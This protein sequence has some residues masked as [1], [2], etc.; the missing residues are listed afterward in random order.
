MPIAEIE[1]KN[2][3][4]MREVEHKSYTF[5][6]DKVGYEVI[7]SKGLDGNSQ[8]N[9]FVTGY[10]STKDLDLYN[11]IVTEDCLKDMLNQLKTKNIKLDVEHEA[12]RDSPNIIPVGKIVEAHLD[13]KGVWVKAQLNP[14][15]PKFTNVWE[16]IRGGFIDAFSI[17]FKAVKSVKKSMDNGVVRLLSQVNLLNVALT[18]N[19]VNPDCTIGNV[20]MKSINEME[21]IEE[22]KMEIE[23]KDEVVEEQPTEVVETPA[24][25]VVEKPA[26]P[27]EEKDNEIKALSELVKKMSEELNSV[28][29]DLAKPQLKAISEDKPKVEVKSKITGTLDLI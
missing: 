18:G 11:D 25:E 5:F 26:E 4:A 20:F 2:N 15:S 19:P 16:S 12:Y 24:E 27:V 1:V 10:I 28:R 8:K 3:S 22:E 9:Y 7:E 17:A 14:A 23:K 13:G 6:T 21:S 29:K